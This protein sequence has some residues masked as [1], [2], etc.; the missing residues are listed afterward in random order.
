MRPLRLTVTGF[1]PYAGT[2]VVDFRAAMDAGVFGIYGE[3]G[4]GKTSIF[5][6][7]AFALFGQSS[8][9]ERSSDDMIS[10]HADPKQLTRVELVFDLGEKRYVIQRIPKQERAANRGD[11]TTAQA[12]EAYLFDAT[13]LSLEDITGD[14]S[15]EI[16]AEKRV[17]VVDPKIR[18]LLGYDAA[19]FRQIVLLPQGEFRK[20]LTADSDERSP[21]LKRLFDVSLYEGIVQRAKFKANAM[22][23]EIREERVRRDERLEGSTIVELEADIG[24]RSKAISDLE[25]VLVKKE[26]D[27]SAQQRNLQIAEAL[28]EKFTALA[29]AKR[30]AANFKTEEE[31]IKKYQ[32]RVKKARAAQSVLP[33][34]DLRNRSQGSQLEAVKQKG[35]ADKLLDETVSKH[36]DSKNALQLSTEQQPLRDQAFAEVHKLERW[37]GILD[38]ASA[39]RQPAEDAKQAFDSAGE[40]EAAAKLKTEQAST[41]LKSLLDLQGEHPKHEKAVSEAR[42]LLVILEQEAALA[43]RYEATL[44]LKTQQAQIVGILQKSHED[45]LE[46]LATCQTNFKAA[47]T[48]L[49]DIQAVHIA[50]KLVG[51]EPCPAC[52][53][54]DHPAPAIGSPERLG[55]HEKFEVTE[56][57]FVEAQEQE[58]TVRGELSSAKAI[59]AERQQ[60]LDIPERG[61]DVLVPLLA[62]AHEQKTSLENDTRFSGLNERLGEAQTHASDAAKSYEQ[63]QK[64]TLAR[65]ADL[66]TAQTTLD[67]ILADVPQEWRDTNKL[68]EAVRSARTDRDQLQNGHQKT[69]DAVQSDAIALASAQEAQKNAASILKQTNTDCEEARTIF[70]EKLAVAAL[71]NEAFAVAKDDIEQLDELETSIRIFEKGVAANIDRIE[72][73]NGEIGEKEQPDLANLKLAAQTGFEQ[74]KASREEKTRLQTELSAKNLLLAAVKKLSDNISRLEERFKPLGAI[75]DLVNGDNDLK[76]RLPDFAIA[77]MFDDILD[78]ANLRLGPMTNHRYQL[79]RPVENTGGRSKRGLDIAVFDSNT[80]RSRS[81][82]S[83]SGGEGFQASLALALGLSDIVQQNGGGIKLEAIF[84]DEGFGTL[85]EETLNTALDTL[86]SLTGEMRAVGLISHTEQVKALI[87]EGF[88]IEVTPSGSHIHARPPSRLE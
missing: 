77:A 39:L 38:K 24:A 23:Q 31:A 44:S 83:L 53:S 70:V 27:N 49:I 88:D 2:E 9:A 58:R 59:L 56:R 84:I 57:E 26:A 12:H 78:A 42:A 33:A 66:S 34:E 67:T 81:T 45:A 7:I 64:D 69:I 54:I 76:I 63:A 3:T 11:G 46:H 20:I 6:G 28:T 21:I 32:E 13:G 75:S 36:E 17:S 16:M 61:Q 71:D 86:C 40:L 48:E 62:E 30:D 22:R 19:Q 15:G 37:Q 35:I 55:R 47:E 4:A 74:L 10:H 1:G 82:K 80:E 50:R 85:D 79:H 41:G 8:G 73:L 60:A 43:G 52:G 51:G 68:A 5:D 29:D 25:E 14:K 65:K 72:R 87:T 18:E